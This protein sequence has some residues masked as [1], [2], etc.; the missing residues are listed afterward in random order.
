MKHSHKDK[1]TSFT[2]FTKDTKKYTDRG[3]NLK[4]MTINNFIE[5]YQGFIQDGCEYLTSLD[6]KNDTNYEIYL[7]VDIS[8]DTKHTMSADMKK[9]YRKCGKERRLRLDQKYNY[10]ANIFNRIHGFVIVQHSPGLSGDKTLAINVI[11]SSNYTTIKGIGTYMMNRV[12]DYSRQSGYK[13]IVLEVGSDAIEHYESESESEEESEEEYNEIDDEA[14]EYFLESKDVG[15]LDVESDDNESLYD[16]DIDQIT[17]D[18]CD[19]ISDELWKKSVRHRNSI[20]YYS[21][22]SVYVY[23]I[24]EA[25]IS[26]NTVKD[27]LPDI[28]ANEEH[29]Y[30]GYYYNKSKRRSSQL[31][32]YYGSFGFKEDP[33]V[34]KKLKCFSELP[35]PS[36]K[37]AL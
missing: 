24:L 30:G 9:K 15:G 13:D 23:S 14:E 11:C 26:N 29:G 2:G 17:E 19:I 21:F 28:I 36:L 18:V 37:L 22:G 25:I 34:H 8:E 7:L 1:Q 16:I 27:P 31:I 35:F 5:E 12:I 32:K 10:E 6:K 4:F 20:P 3:W 33:N